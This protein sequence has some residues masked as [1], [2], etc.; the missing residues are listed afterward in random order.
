[1]VEGHVRWYRG[2]LSKEVA[3]ETAWADTS[4]V[5]SVGATLLMCAVPLGQTLLM[6][7]LRLMLP[8]GSA[9]WAK[10]SARGSAG[11]EREGLHQSRVTE[12]PSSP[13]CS[14]K[15]CGLCGDC[16][17]VHHAQ[18]VHTHTRTHTQCSNS[19]ILNWKNTKK[20]ILYW[21][22]TP[23]GKIK[24]TRAHFQKTCVQEFCL[25][26]IHLSYIQ[27]NMSIICHFSI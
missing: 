5:S 22:I 12:K 6:P 23:M 16:Q 25:G 7:L 21:K 9:D 17:T 13:E 27:D 18:Q 24:H 4:Q 19:L 26:H 10:Q 3:A 20:S 8:T 11:I 15:G 14:S 1:M 2:S